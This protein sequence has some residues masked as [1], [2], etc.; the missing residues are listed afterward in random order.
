MGI[1]TKDGILSADDLKTITLEIPEWDGS[2][3]IKAMS[4]RERDMFE[5]AL[6]TQR[7]DKTH[8]NMRN[9]RARMAVL[10]VYNEDMTPMFTMADMG[11]LG[12]KS[13]AAL[14]RIFDACLKLNRFKKE[15]IDEL[16]DGIEKNPFESSASDLP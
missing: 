15:D 11:R 7:G 1:L 4:G 9:A 8:V 10:S 6:V 14:D 3:L 13:S 5:E 12:E 2:V 16:T